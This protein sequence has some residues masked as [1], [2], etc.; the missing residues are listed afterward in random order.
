[1]KLAWVRSAALVLKRRALDCIITAPST[2]TANSSSEMTT[3]SRL[4]PFWRMS[5]FK[6]GHPASKWIAPRYC[7][8][9]ERSADVTERF[10]PT[11]RLNVW[12]A[13]LCEVGQ[14]QY[15]D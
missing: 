6:I 15:A 3:S 10:S 14:A 12:P 9:L 4:K 1:M 5:R 8:L 7:P 2:P 11:H 13:A